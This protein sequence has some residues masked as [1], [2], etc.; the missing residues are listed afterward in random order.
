MLKILRRN[1]NVQKGE[2]EII[3]KANFECLLFGGKYSFERTNRIIS[4]IIKKL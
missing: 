3:K 2:L 1:R 4:K